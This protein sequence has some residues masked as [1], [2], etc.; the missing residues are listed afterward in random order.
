MYRLVFDECV[1]VIWRFGQ[2][3]LVTADFIEHL[4][5]RLDLGR[6]HDALLLEIKVVNESIYNPSRYPPASLS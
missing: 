1:F 3:C 4:K 2:D 6:G 5:P